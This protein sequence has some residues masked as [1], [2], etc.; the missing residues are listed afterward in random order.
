M[1][2]SVGYSDNP[3]TALA[4]RLAVRNALEKSG[5]GGPCDV[6]LL[7]ATAR[8]EAAALRA[9]V[10]AAVGRE[11]PIYGGGAVGAIAND[12]FGYAGD[13]VILAAI[14]LEETRLDFARETG[15]AESEEE[16]G[17]RLGKK[18]RGLS[19]SPQSAILLFYD[20]IFR[21]PE[22][23]RLLMATPLL[24]GIEQGLGFLPSMA[25]AG[26]QGDFVLSP[27][28]QWAGD[29]IIEHSALALKFSDDVRIDTT[30]MHGCRPAT[31][32]YTVTKADRQTILEINHRPALAFLGELLGSAVPV[33]SFPFFLILGVNQGRKWGV[34]DEKSY[35]SRLCLAIDKERSGLVM[36]EPDMV[37]GTEFQIMYRSLEL[38]YM[39][40]RIE[41]LFAGLG[42]RKPVFSM[43]INCAGRAAGYGGID[44]ED[45]AVVQNIV[46]DRV[47]LLGLYTGVEIAPVE[48]RPRGLD[49]TG[50]FCLFSMST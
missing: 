6:M 50:V 34:F 44:M 32:Y 23:V 19:V 1:R 24:R 36:F 10:T 40:P 22:G 13:Q 33:E 25:G 31:G 15:L 4:G 35:A 11:L 49:C 16:T 30:I 14:W 12:T 3:D 8:H 43:Y 27:S 2:V 47:P 39:K 9:A 26:L 45:A 20:A 21:T 46:A 37:E 42:G 48:G 38:D 29:T 41:Q 17:I 28:R 5:Q 18:L 7:F